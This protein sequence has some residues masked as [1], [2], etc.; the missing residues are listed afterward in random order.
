MEMVFNS[1]KDC[2]CM[3]YLKKKIYCT[4]KTVHI[5]MVQS[6]KDK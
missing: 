3:V 4:S 5:W 1:D 2:I 6:D